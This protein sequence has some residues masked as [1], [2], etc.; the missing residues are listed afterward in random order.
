[1]QFPPPNNKK[2][3]LHG[4]ARFSQTPAPPHTLFQPHTLRD[5]LVDSPRH[6]GHQGAPQHP[7]HHALKV[8]LHAVLVMDVHHHRPYTIKFIGVELHF[9]FEHIGGLGD[10][11]GENAGGDATR[12]VDRGGVR[13]V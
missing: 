3:L 6:R 4:G 2:T 12:E 8:A 11:G 7:R 13:G 10:Q 1:M 9:C 5:M